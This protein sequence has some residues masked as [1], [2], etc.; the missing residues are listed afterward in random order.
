MKEVEVLI[1]GGGPVGL[2][3]GRALAAKG[4]EVLVA[5]F[6]AYPVDK[7]C[8]EGLMPT[9]LASLARLGVDPPGV[10]FTGISY[11]TPGGGHVV[12]DFAE[13]P[14]RGVRRTE[15][16][17]AL[18]RGVDFEVRQRSRVRLV[19]RSAAG[20]LAQVGDEMVLARLVV[21]ADGLG[22]HVRAFA[23]LDG[24]PATVR[25]FG[26]R[27]HFQSHRW[28]SR[29]EVYWQEGREAYVTPSG[30]DQVG[31]AI[32]WERQ[33]PTDYDTLLSGFPQVLG[34]LGPPRSDTAIIGPLERRALGPVAPGI[35]LVGDAAGYLDAI[36]GEGLSLGFAQGLALARAALPALN[37]TKGLAPPLWAY[38]KRYR[39]IMQP[40]YH[41]TRLALTMS[42]HPWLLETVAGFLPG[43]GLQKLLSYAMGEGTA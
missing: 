37:G 43:A 30:L 3:A 36:T 16:S 5:E 8:G 6:Q 10:P 26:A 29:V 25:R 33:G 18:L 42:R 1:V 19:Q 39:K 2:F 34:G 9:G 24:P 12:A 40:Y 11:H 31:V 41:T 38:Q 27:R 28:S 21:G 15:L 23:G 20:V 17:K 7:A 22:S 4:V 13:G 32:L 35:A 14:G